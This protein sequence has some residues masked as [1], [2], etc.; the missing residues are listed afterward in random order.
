MSWLGRLAKGVR[1]ATPMGRR[2]AQ[3]DLDDELRSCFEL[4]VDRHRARGLSA[5][6]ARRQA[7]LEFGDVE[8]IREHVR[9][10]GAGRGPGLLRDLRYAARAVRRSPAVTAAA[11][12]TLA[13][14][15]GVTA[16]IFSAVDA[17]LVQPFP[18]EHAEK[19]ALI[20]SSFEKT[21]AVRAPTSGIALRE[22]RQRTRLLQD[23]AGIWASTG[24]L[25][26]T[27]APEVINVGNVTP[28]FLA[29]LG[30][31]PVLGRLFSSDE[32]AGGRAAMVLTHGLWQR[33]FG[34]DPQIL[35]KAVSFRGRPVTVVGVLPADF[36]LLFPAD[37]N[38]PAD[39]QAFCPFAD[40]IESNPVDLYYIRVLARLR[41]GVTAEQAQA[42]L[43]A[44]A[45]S[46]RRDYAVLAAE[47]MKLELAPL[48]SDAVRNIR[49]PLLALLAGA[50]F[51]LLICCVNVANLQLAS[52]Q[53]RRKEIALRSALGAGAS[54][55][56]RQLLLEG[57]LTCGVAGLLG[58]GVAI[59]G[60]RGLRAIE[61]LELSRLPQGGVSGSMILLVVL[62]ALGAALLFGLAP[63]SGLR[64]LALVEALREG[65][66]T[67]AAPRLRRSRAVLIVAEV[68]LGFV[69]VVAAGLMIRSLTQIGHVS[70]GFEAN[71]L[72][73]FDVS[74][75]R[76]QVTQ[77]VADYESRLA[78]LPGVRAVGAVSHLPLA[79]YPNWYGPYRV[80]GGEDKQGR[81]QAADHRAI[82]PGYFPAMG[83]HLLAGR[84]FDGRDS[85]KAPPVAIID[86][87]L[88]SSAWPGRSP[89]G[90]KI[91]CEHFTA[92][93]IVPVWSVVVGVVEHVHN[94]ALTSTPRGEVYLPYAQ[95]PREHLSFV[96]RTPLPPLA[97]VADVRRLTAA[98]DP[99][100]GLSKVRPMS[101]YL[102]RALAPANFTAWLAGVFGAL[103]LLLAGIGLYG[104]ISYSVGWRTREM[105]VR[106]AL[107]AA[108]SAVRLLVLR[109][110]MTLAVLGMVLGTGGALLLSRSLQSLVYGI[111]AIDPVSYG[112]AVGT[113]VVA[114]LA[115]CW[116]P[117]RSA[118]LSD[119]VQAL[120]G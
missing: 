27:V 111:P 13:L 59:A 15:I 49:Q 96:I 20:W 7:R 104:V 89:L 30:V 36:R 48:Q 32:R 40:D 54:G 88:A 5:S 69:L 103:A 2:E 8:R 113:V 87:L 33:R 25:T 56:L 102:D 72:L 109:E 6:E 43:S 23:V 100:L 93:G 50:G 3:L 38:V 10:T 75:A 12:L 58:L 119:P 24:T 83:T 31:R 41:P 114:A 101:F 86:D 57:L 118:A 91:E 92:A 65:G 29:V 14:G 98:V 80:T 78:T 55:V 52:A 73:T 21:G 22:I 66:H 115:G 105:G 79:D 28:N 90:K 85:E 77:F 34:S 84:F 51:V 67:T 117:A 82:T 120:R 71:G 106:M 70:P 46:I 42:D 60:I 97:L 68:T 16:A 61:P 44:A 107:G 112:L 19:L 11:V 76:R 45:A 17:V 116:R 74:L 110:A 4:V 81:S 108:R 64:R 26:G 39:V 95:S 9:N 99:Q 53:R 35:G 62:V 47:N 94:H 37:A 63:G 18:Y 1:A